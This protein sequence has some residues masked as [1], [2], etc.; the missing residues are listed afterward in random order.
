[1]F[2]PPITV[3]GICRLSRR[4][5]NVR[6]EI[7]KYLHTSSPG[8]IPFFHNR[9]A[10]VVE[11]FP[12]SLLRFTDSRK[13]SLYLFA[14]AV[15]KIPRHDLLTFNGFTF[16]G[17][18]PRRSPD[19]RTCLLSKYRATASCPGKFA[20]Y[21]WRRSA[22][23]THPGCPIIPPIPAGRISAGP[24]RRGSIILPVGQGALSMSS[25]RRKR[26]YPYFFGIKFYMVTGSH[27]GYLP[28][29]SRL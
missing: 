21:V 19:R 17:I 10:V 18:L 2:R 14:F 27:W 20:V 1:M 9:R 5:C 7:C 12:Q 22:A 29:G 24:L 4:F 3:K 13:G 25:P 6:G 8:E 15:Q 26:F 28:C 16:R 11:G 23:G